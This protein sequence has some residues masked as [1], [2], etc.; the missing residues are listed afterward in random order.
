M[1]LLITFSTISNVHLLDFPTPAINLN[2]H[3]FVCFVA[4]SFLP[5]IHASLWWRM[6]NSAMSKINTQIGDE[7]KC[8]SFLRRQ[9]ER[10][11][12][13]IAATQSFVSWNLWSCGFDIF[14][15]F[16]MFDALRFMIIKQCNVNRE[17]K[18]AIWLMWQSS[19]TCYMC[20]GTIIIAI[21]SSLTNRP[22]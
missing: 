4:K 17:L 16:F 18:R 6:R 20:S 2:E 11:A 19:A 14:F 8:R 12:T 5:I 1:L 13:W 22:K 7:E 15:R 21:A 9:K 10:H 3:E